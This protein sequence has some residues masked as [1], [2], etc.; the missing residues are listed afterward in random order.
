M[1]IFR[2]FLS[3]F[4]FIASQVLIDPLYAISLQNKSVSKTRLLKRMIK[5]KKN[6]F[7]KCL[8]SRC[9]K[10]K[11]RKKV[12]R[13]KFQRK[14]KQTRKKIIRPV[15]LSVNSITIPNST[16]T[17]KIVCN[18]L[19]IGA[20]YK[21]HITFAREK[22]GIDR[23]TFASAHP[24]LITGLNGISFLNSFPVQMGL[25][26]QR[27]IPDE[28]FFD[29]YF[30]HALRNFPSFGLSNINQLRTT[31]PINYISGTNETIT[32]LA[33]YGLLGI[34]EQEF[35]ELSPN[36]KLVNAFISAAHL[37]LRHD[38]KVLGT[39][40]S[41]SFVTSMFMKFVG[42]RII[43]AYL[44]NPENWFRFTVCNVMAAMALNLK[45]SEVI[46]RVVGIKNFSHLEFDA[47]KL[48]ALEIEKLPNGH[49]ILQEY[50]A[51]ASERDEKLRQERA[52]A[53]GDE[54]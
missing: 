12:V 17:K 29:P 28:K 15:T 35:N 3:L 23:G 41:T 18:I 14:K 32:S 37:K 26:L 36:V 11:Q 33:G 5:R 20:S 6:R 10:K 34:N 54:E 25:L 2:F 53:K 44:V 50:V 4:L 46:G 13:H 52:M 27:F 1:K 30:V 40:I 24:W 16:K 38:Q 9:P 47:L 19:P 7:K 42:S 21:D 31:I 49:E 43:A 8:R 51:W 45:S 48:A 39:N 22:L